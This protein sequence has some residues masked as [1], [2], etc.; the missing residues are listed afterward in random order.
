M[1][2]G[3][4]ARAPKIVNMYFNTRIEEGDDGTPSNSCL[5]SQAPA[6][7]LFFDYVA[8]F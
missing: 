8:L 7:R 3:K 2:L 4:M 1:S 5:A 6:H